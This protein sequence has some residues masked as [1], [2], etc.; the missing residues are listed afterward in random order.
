MGEMFGKLQVSYALAK[1]HRE[2]IMGM[3]R[4]YCIKSLVPHNK[5]EHTYNSDACNHLLL[6]AGLLN[7]VILKNEE[8]Y[9]VGFPSLNEDARGAWDFLV[10]RG[11]TVLSPLSSTAQA[12]V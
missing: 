2:M 9:E 3:N 4:G 5:E 10:T 7:M 6:T 12:K 8:G 1:E 11:A